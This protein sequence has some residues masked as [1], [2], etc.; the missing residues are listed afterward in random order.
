VEDVIL[1]KCKYHV[2]S[3]KGLSSKL[4]ISLKTLQDWF[5]QNKRY[6]P[7][8]IIDSS[9]IGKLEILDTKE[10]NW[11]QIKGGKNASKTKYANPSIIKVI[12]T[13]KIIFHLI[14]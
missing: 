14:I 8:E 6:I 13:T 12:K 11:G 2:N 5:Y 4:N 7:N 10:D 1:L 9:W 3:V